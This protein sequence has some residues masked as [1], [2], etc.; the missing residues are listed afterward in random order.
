MKI[1]KQIID[2]KTEQKSVTLDPFLPQIFN[3]LNIA[4]SKNDENKEKE[5]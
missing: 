3:G 5:K 1:R 2:L 4:A